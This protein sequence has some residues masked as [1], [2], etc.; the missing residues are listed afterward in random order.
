V[1]GRGELDPMWAAMTNLLAIEKEE[2]GGV[3]RRSA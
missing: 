3:H 1:A 2:L